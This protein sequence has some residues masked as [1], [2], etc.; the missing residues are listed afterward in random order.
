MKIV[1]IQLP[2]IL[3][4]AEI[5]EALQIMALHLPVPET[6]A[7][8]VTAEWTQLIK[9]MESLSPS[10][11][12]ANK[13]DSILKLCC[14]PNSNISTITNFWSNINS[15]KITKGQLLEIMRHP[16]VARIHLKKRNAEC[17]F[18]LFETALKHL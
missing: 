2:S 18:N 6:A 7:N 17:F 15:S 13:C 1:V 14:D 8:Q 4:D 11:D 9:S 16:T 10:N 12:I 3:S 5:K